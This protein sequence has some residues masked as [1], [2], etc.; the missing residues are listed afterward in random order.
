VLLLAAAAGGAP[1]AGPRVV[2]SESLAAGSFTVPRGETVVVERRLV[3]R[4]RRS[5]VIAGRLELAPGADLRLWAGRDVRVSGEIVPARGR[6]L[7][8]SA[9]RPSQQ[10]IQVFGKGLVSVSGRILGGFAFRGDSYVPVPGQSIVISTDPAGTIEVSGMLATADGEPGPA[11]RVPGGNAGDIVMHGAFGKVARIELNP[12]ST[13]RTG[14]GGAG[15]VDT[16]VGRSVGPNPCGPGGERRV[17]DLLGGDGGD[18]GNVRLLAK[19][20]D[21][22]GTIELG[23][24]GSGGA[25]GDNTRAASGGPDQGGADLR[26]ESGS[27]GRGGAFVAPGSP[28]QATVDAGVGGDGGAIDAVAGNGGPNCDG[29]SAAVVLGRAGAPGSPGR[30]PRANSHHGRIV[31][32]NG[33]NGGSATDGGHGGGD[34]GSL[35][36]RLPQ[37][38]LG[39]IVDVERV[40]NGGAGFDGCGGR[41]SHGTAGGDAGS[42]SISERFFP[43]VVEQSFDGG[44]GGDGDPVGLGG[45]EGRG[46]PADHGGDSFRH[47]EHGSPCG[48]GAAAAATLTT[49]T[50]AASPGAC[51][52]YLDDDANVAESQFQV[53]CARTAYDTLTLKVPGHAVGPIYGA[54]TQGAG[55]SIGCSKSAPGTI[56]CKLRPPF[57]ATLASELAFVD[58]GF[59]D[60]DPAVT[61]AS[62][63]GVVVTATL[64]DHGGPVA[65]KTGVDASVGGGKTC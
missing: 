29:G 23:R 11:S 41:V 39:G 52:F 22:R 50:A 19:T 35:S 14:N 3:V 15:F 30:P 4:A 62:S 53:T 46:A 2:V 26:A 36:I 55:Y 45:A 10:P 43:P 40:G 38:D 57:P 17:L 59:A 1:A 33:G 20:I 27:G 49:T 21:A 44:R 31:L 54:H 25:A 58:F 47:G 60:G 13:L 65:A 63:C 5:I 37:N 61:K 48:G 12:G 18:G 6:S 7:L 9:G 32:A 28:L 56:V 42:F 51:S 34:G 64:T 24:G 16:G 8:A